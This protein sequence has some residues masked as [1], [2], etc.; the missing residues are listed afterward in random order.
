MV[1]KIN[2]I[3]G[4]FDLVITPAPGASAIT[5]LQAD[6]TNLASPSG[7]TVTI[8]GGTNIVT[9]AAGTTLTIDFDGTLPVASGGTGQTTYTDGQLLIGNSTG[10]TLAK[11]TLTEG[12][13]IDI[14]N[15]SGS[16]TIA[17]EDAAAGV[18]SANKG[19]CS[20]ESSDFSVS[21]GHVSLSGNI[22]TTATTDSGTATS[23]GGNINFVGSGAISTS[24]AS[25]TVTI[26]I[27]DPVTVGNGGTG[28]S[29]L[30]DGGILLGS[31][32]GAITATGQPTNGQVLIGSTGGDPVLATLTAGAG[33]SIANGA[34]TITISDAGAAGFSWN[35]VTTTTQA[36]TAANG[37]I[38][39]NAS[40][41]TFTLPATGTVGDTIRVV[42]LGVGGWQIDQNASQVIHFGSSDTTTGTG[43]SLASTH[44]Y[45]AVE[46]ACVATDTDWTIL[47]SIGN[48][49]VT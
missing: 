25:D 24:G 45:D 11:A 46:F 9:S 48:I 29:S 28:A 12:E 42:G 14:T 41:V 47:S 8:A 15:G 1:Q 39:N 19:V 23:S 21:S 26:A 43:G 49:T 16:I 3:T 5:D 31:G 27:E 37:Y 44:K 2:P 30:T 10:N 4:K 32:T 34:G 13:G 18:G 6:D 36:M 20:F 17:G 7:G 22:T 35:D 40:K 33:I 38:A